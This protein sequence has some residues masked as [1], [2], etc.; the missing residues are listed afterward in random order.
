MAEPG[1]SPGGGR[2]GQGIPLI[3]RGNIQGEGGWGAGRALLPEDLL[4]R[5]GTWRLL[6]Y[7]EVPAELMG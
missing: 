1:I 3:R 5:A 6:L 4:A 7:V 2:A